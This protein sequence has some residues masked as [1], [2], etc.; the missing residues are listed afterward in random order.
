MTRP[1]YL[2]L[3]ANSGLG[4]LNQSSPSPASSRLVSRMTTLHEENPTSSA[5]GVLSPVLATRLEATPETVE[6]EDKVQNIW[7]LVIVS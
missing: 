2:N 6:D 1:N 7:K 5:Q 4:R 3:N